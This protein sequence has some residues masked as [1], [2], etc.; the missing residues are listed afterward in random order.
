M[1]IEEAMKSPD[2]YDLRLVS[3]DVW[4]F[5]DDTKLEWVVLKCARYQKRN[6]ILYRGDSVTDAVNALVNS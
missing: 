6:S 5:W 2:I 1:N 3:G 4:M